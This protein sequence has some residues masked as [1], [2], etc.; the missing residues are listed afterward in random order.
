EW[1][2]GTESVALFNPTDLDTDQ[3]VRVAQEA[4]IKLLILTAKHHDGFCLWPTHTTDYSIRN[5]RYKDGKGDI[6][7]ELSESCK[8]YGMKLGVYLSPWDRNAASYGTDEYNKMFMN[9]LQEVLTQYGTIDE[10]WFD[11][12][13][14]EGPNGKKQ[15]YDWA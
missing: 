5:S 13:N 15:E 10:V 8:K 12:A 7:K 11:G 1:G 9:Q 14:G 6:L 2:D 4:G 3:W